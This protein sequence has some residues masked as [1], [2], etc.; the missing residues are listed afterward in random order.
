MDT[1][2]NNGL[3]FSSV[4]KQKDRKE[5]RHRCGYVRPNQILNVQQACALLNV[6]VPKLPISYKFL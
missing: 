2:T 3:K 6:V 4:V 1:L 5:V